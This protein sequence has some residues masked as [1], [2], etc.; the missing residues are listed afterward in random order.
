V[1]DFLELYRKKLSE[2]YQHIKIVSKSYQHHIKARSKS[3]QNRKILGETNQKPIVGLVSVSFFQANP[4][5]TPKS[6]SIPKLS[7]YFLKPYPKPY[8]NHN[9]IMI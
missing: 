2:S 3:H 4:P 9:K 8:Q 7:T 6:R 5:E 1:L